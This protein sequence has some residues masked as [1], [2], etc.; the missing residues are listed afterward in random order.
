MDVAFGDDQMRARSGHAAHNLAVLK[1]ITLNR[2][3][4][5]NQHFWRFLPALNL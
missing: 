1:Q 2:S 5:P 3:L 4:T